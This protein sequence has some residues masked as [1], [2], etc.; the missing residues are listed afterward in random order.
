MS[1][2]FFYRC[3]VCRTFVLFGSVEHKGQRF[4]SHRCKYT[5][6][7]LPE[8]CDTCKSDSTQEVQFSGGGGSYNGTG[9]RLSGPN[10]TCS[11]CTSTLRVHWSIALMYHTRI[12]G[13]YRMIQLEDGSFISRGATAPSEPALFT[14]R[15]PG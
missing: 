10:E 13:A 15:G 4:C 2:S 12:L 6:A 14:H 8:F 3:D 5:V 9:S 1:V 7:P 11:K